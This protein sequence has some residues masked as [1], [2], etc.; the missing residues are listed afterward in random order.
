MSALSG[1]DNVGRAQASFP[2]DIS[3]E[4]S[5]CAGALKRALYKF[6]TDS[7]LSSSPTLNLKS[8]CALQQLQR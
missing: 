6:E 3:F 1:I 4:K 8:L 5:C 7:S 2:E